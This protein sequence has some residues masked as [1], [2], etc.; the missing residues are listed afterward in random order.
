MI[1]K[2]IIIFCKPFKIRV[3][4]D[5]LHLIKR[6]RY[7]LFNVIIHS[8]FHQSNDFFDIQ[9]LQ[10]IFPKIPNIVWSDEP[11]TKMHDSLPLLLFDPKNLLVLLE[12]KYFTEA[13]YFFP[14]SI[15]IL[16]F[17]QKNLGYSKRM[18]LLQIAFYYL[19]YFYEEMINE[20]E[21]DLCETKRGGIHLM[22]FSKQIL[23]EF[24]NTLHCN[25]Q[26][27]NNINCF[28]FRRNFTG[29]L[30]NKFGNIRRRSKYV[31]TLEKF[32]QVVGSLQGIERQKMI[33]KRKRFEDEIEIHCRN[34]SFGVVVE[35][36]IS[37]DT[38]SFAENDEENDNYSGYFP[39]Q[40]IA[41]A[42]L[43]FAG[44]DYS[45]QSLVSPEDALDNFL[46]FF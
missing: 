16:A 14:I 25:I 21:I 15:S 31:H 3:S 6:L 36:K 40:C 24:L 34:N 43:H 10:S 9:K 19:S 17:D 29:P 8:G 37:D 44:F 12:N 23:I 18:Y 42:M 28:S 46:I 32:L 11:Y 27:M 35:E 39:P 38:D 33:Y 13:G 5:F 45:Y 22:Y 20:E 1:K 2:N 30:E 41:K 26:L 7:R 4:T